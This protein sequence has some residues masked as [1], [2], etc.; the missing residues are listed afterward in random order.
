[1]VALQT[2]HACPGESAFHSRCRTLSHP[3]SPLGSVPPTVSESRR[4]AL[5]KVDASAPVTGK[6]LENFVAM[7]VLRHAGWDARRARLYHY[8]RDKEDIDLVLEW[9]DGTFAGIDVKA[10]ATVDTSDAKWLVKL[11]TTPLGDRLWAIPVSGLWA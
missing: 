5:H 8:Q 10:S 2:S 4:R 11:Q 6:A 3:P 1:M 7:E 9:T